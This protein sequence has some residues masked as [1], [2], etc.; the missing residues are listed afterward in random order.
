MIDNLKNF[1]STK[2]YFAAKAP[3]LFNLEHI[4]FIIIASIVIILIAVL[5]RKIKHEKLKVIFIVFWIIQT[6]LEVIK[7]IWYTVAHKHFFAEYIIPIHICSMYMYVMPFVIWGKGKVKTAALSFMATFGLL[8]GLVNFFI[9]SVLSDFP[10]LSFGG[11]HSMFFHFIMV[12]TAVLMWT[13]GFYKPKI[14]DAFYSFLTLLIFSVPVIILDKV[15]GFDYMFYNGGFGTPLT[16]LSSLMHPTLW[17]FV[18]L[19]LYFIGNSLV[20]YLPLF[21]INK[22]RNKKLKMNKIN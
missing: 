22:A 19:I 18:L 17:T 11:F 16:I 7:I 15:T 14:K 5:L 4:L 10:I 13:T 6:S 20:F 1:F 2:T 9:P 3:Y 12:L 21:I 8:G